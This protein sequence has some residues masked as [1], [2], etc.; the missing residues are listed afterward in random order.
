MNRVG[1]LNNREESDKVQVISS[2]KMMGALI[3]EVR[4]C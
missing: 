4:G 2:G 1:D 3:R